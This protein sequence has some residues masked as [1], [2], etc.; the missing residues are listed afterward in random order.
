MRAVKAKALRKMAKLVT[1]GQPD[2][3]LV[4]HDQQVMKLVN[5][6]RQPVMVSYAVNAPETTRGVYRR[7]K[8]ISVKG[9]TVFKDASPL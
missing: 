1:Q 9:R 6:K 3:R 8:K 2:R 7:W 5:G 4:W